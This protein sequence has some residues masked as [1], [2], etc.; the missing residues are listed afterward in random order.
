M[1][2]EHVTRPAF[3]LRTRAPGGEAAR[4][5]QGHTAAPAFR[6]QV[7]RRGSLGHAFTPSVSGAL[8]RP[9]VGLHALGGV[10]IVLNI[11]A[12]WCVPCQQE[13]PLLERTWEHQGRPGGTLF[14]GLDQQDTTGDAR[15]FLRQYGIDYPNLHD[16]GNDVP[17]NYGA[18]GVPDTFFIDA[19]GDIVAH[20]IGTAS[21]NQL[22][23]GISAARA[24]HPLQVRPGGA[25]RHAR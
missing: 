1:T 4:L 17:R 7:L 2:H 16:A 11:W 24:G 13:A 5:A 14:L 6:L 20:I 12:S 15:G 10:P 21:A 22:S 18:T 9:Y 25:R 23:A 19:Q 8:E 3:G